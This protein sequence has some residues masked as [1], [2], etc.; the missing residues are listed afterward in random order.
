M[1]EKLK[2]KIDYELQFEEDVTNRCVICWLYVNPGS[3][4][5]YLRARQILGMFELRTTFK[6]TAHAHNGRSLGS[7]RS[8]TFGAQKGTP[9]ILL[10]VRQFFPQKCRGLFGVGRKVNNGICR[11]SESLLD[12]GCRDHKPRLLRKLAEAKDQGITTSEKGRALWTTR[13]SCRK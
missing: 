3:L 6:A 4:F 9:Q 11:L 1:N 7:G 10:A 5:E 8:K 2:R 13:S 12:T